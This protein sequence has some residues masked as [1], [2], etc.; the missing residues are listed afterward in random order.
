[1]YAICPDIVK[2]FGAC[3]RTVHEM[4]AANAAGSKP[5]N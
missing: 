1:V 4:H 3:E 5:P 2:P